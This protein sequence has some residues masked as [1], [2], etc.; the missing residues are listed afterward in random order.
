MAQ[1]E[2]IPWNAVLSEYL[3][4]PT[5]PTA[6]DLAEQFGCSISSINR[7]A[8]RDN[9]KTLREEHQAAIAEQ[10]SS[11]L[12]A[13]AADLEVRIRKE[14]L[15]NAHGMQALGAESIQKHLEEM[16]KTGKPVPV[17]VARHLVVAAAEMQRKALGIPEV[18]TITEDELDAEIRA[19]LAKLAKIQGGK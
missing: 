11:D 15:E 19:E 14:Q 10:A 13:I 17:T 6:G 9:W 18:L 4:A 7:R 12:A 3:N 2:K 8:S 5:R 16:R 1:R